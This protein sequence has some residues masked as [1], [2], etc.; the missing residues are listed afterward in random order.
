MISYY[1]VREYRI[2]DTYIILYT[3]Y[4]IG[5]IVIDMIA[6]LDNVWLSYIMHIIEFMSKWQLISLYACN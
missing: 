2:L 6:V 5:R 3:Y 4:L 1:G